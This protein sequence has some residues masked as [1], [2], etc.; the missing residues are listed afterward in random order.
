MNKIR[1]ILSLLLSVSLLFS[2]VPAVF[3]VQATEEEQPVTSGQCGEDVFWEYDADT[4]TLTFDGTGEMYSYAYSSPWESLKN[5]IETAVVGDEIT[6]V[7]DAAFFNCAAL[8]NVVIGRSVQRMTI[9]AF[10]SDTEAYF[11]YTLAP[12]ENL[13]VNEEN[14]FFSSRDNVLYNKEQTEL[15]YYPPGLDETSFVLPETVKTVASK[16]FD[17]NTTLEEIVLNEGLEKIASSAF[18]KC[19]ALSNISIPDTVSSVYADAFKDS[20]YYNNEKNRENGVLYCGAWVLNVP[21]SVSNL[22][23]R[24]GTVGIAVGAVE[25]G[26]ILNESALTSVFLPSSLRYLTDG[27]W[28]GCK[29]LSKISVHADNP[30]LSSRNGILY[31]KEKTK[32]LCFPAACE[33]TSFIVPETVREIAPSALEYCKKLL[34]VTLP[35]GL[36]RIG[37]SAFYYCSNLENLNLPET[38]TDIGSNAFCG[39][40]ELNFET[41]PKAVAHIGDWAFVGTVNYAKMGDDLFLYVD[42][43]LV[44]SRRD[45]NI[46]RIEIKD[47]TRLIADKLFLYNFPSATEIF[48]PRSLCRIGE[49]AATGLENLKWVYYDGTPEEWKNISIA[50]RNLPLQ[51]AALCTSFVKGSVRY[52]AEGISVT[53]VPYR[54]EN[55]VLLVAGLCDGKLSEVKTALCT[56]KEETFLLKDTV[57]TVI[58]YVWNRNLSSEIKPER[59]EKKDFL[60]Q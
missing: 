59:I 2:A 14:E 20:A 27:E 39:C 56:G 47:G 31:D 29:K 44:L 7:T 37:D 30:V 38:L 45:E 40:S 9:F 46:S 23:V 5:E 18:F 4:K 49:A 52:T 16:A 13:T 11:Q 8:K 10:R 34:S 19:T 42:D 6:S 48:L 24:E 33:K 60:G 51:N 26:S 21:T 41:I 22:S 12:I 17:S 54:V 25:S 58:L 15:I 57:D 3:S 36:L 32:L 50:E 43:C 1:K 28:A 35:E 55:R 53:V